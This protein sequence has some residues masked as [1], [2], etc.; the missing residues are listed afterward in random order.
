MIHFMS[1]LIV[2]FLGAAYEGVP[3]DDVVRGNNRF[4]VELLGQ[5]RD[6]PGNLFFSPGSLSTA[7]AMAYAGARHETAEQMAKAL[8]FTLPPDRLHPAFASMI[9]SL[10]AGASK[11]GYRLSVA[12]RLWGPKGYHYRPEFLATTR[13]QYGAELSEVDFNASEQA[14]RT[15]NAWIAEKTEG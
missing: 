6:Q 5:V 11:G 2:F 7:L 13:D 12:N 4:A 10:E 1:P 15:I 3:M 14:R 8:H 9:R